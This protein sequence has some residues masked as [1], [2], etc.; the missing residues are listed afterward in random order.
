MRISVHQ[1]VLLP[2]I[3]EVVLAHP[4]WKVDRRRWSDL[5]DKQP[6]LHPFCKRKPD[7]TQLPVDPSSIPKGKALPW[8]VLFGTGEMKSN[9]KARPEGIT[10]SAEGAR[11]IFNTQLNRRHVVGF[12]L[13]DN[14]LSVLAFDRSGL[15][16]SSPFNIHENPSLFLHAMV[17]CLH[18]EETRFGI[19]P[20]VKIDENSKTIQVGEEWYDIIDVLH[21]EGALRG[22][23]TV[24]YHVR[25]DGKDYVVKDSWVDTSR[26]DREPKVLASLSGLKHIPKVIKDCPVYYKGEPDKTSLFRES[27]AG[28]TCTAEIRE[29]RRMLLEP[30]A[31][32]ISDFRDLVEL[33]TAIRDV[34]DGKSFT[35]CSELLFFLLM[36]CVSH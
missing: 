16:A 17:G 33:L 4:E 27:E 3:F 22:R 12:V 1:L 36:Y 29:H 5:Y 18:I 31:H 10:Q 25:K 14:L 15:V 23:G 8:C 35:A 9:V 19:D 11:V 6:V 34:V 2:L 7:A 24:C 32:K 13:T 20:T 21:V 30:C 28:K 26:E